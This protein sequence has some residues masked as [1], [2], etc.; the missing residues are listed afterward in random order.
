MLAVEEVALVVVA[1]TSV[2][3]PA[4]VVV[5]AT[6]ALKVLTV[7][8]EMLV[9]LTAMSVMPT[10]VMAAAIFVVRPSDPATSSNAGGALSE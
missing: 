6:S 4:L 8:V 3:D 5:A 10:A 9:T 1:A 2:C 7:G